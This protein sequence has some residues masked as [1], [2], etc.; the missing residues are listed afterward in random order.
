MDASTLGLLDGF[1]EML[2]AERGASPNTIEA[3]Q[4]DLTQ[5][6]AFAKKRGWQLSTLTQH[7]L[8]AYLA[9]LSKAGLAETS[10]MRK[11]SA[12]KQFFGFLYRERE[13]AD[14][15]SQLLEAP[16]PARSLPHV[17]SRASIAALMNEATADTTSEGVRFLTMLEVLYASGM[18]VSELVGLKLKHIERNPKTGAIAPFMRITGK[19]SKERLVPLHSTAIDALT[20]YLPLRQ[21]F[22]PKGRETSPWLFPSDGKTGHITRQRFGQVLKEYCLR[23][24]LDP[25]Q[26]SPH[27]LRHSFATHLLEGG[28]DLRVIQELLGHADISTTQIYTH[29]SNAH[30]TQVVHSSHPLSTRTARKAKPSKED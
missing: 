4:R 25:S 12:L 3:Y 16:K 5:F 2:A 21:L 22:I 17:L 1:I 15:P 9:S 30:L 6:F 19:G 26:C 10:Q 28:A 13:R 11:R 23:A 14:D 29:V 24:G 27:T 8:S 7:D 20:A 18:R